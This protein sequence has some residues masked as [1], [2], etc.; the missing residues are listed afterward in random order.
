[1]PRNPTTGVY[2]PVENSFSDPVSGTLIEPVDAKQYNDDVTAALNDV[3]IIVNGMP[4]IGGTSGGI[5]FNNG[6]EVSC[7]DSTS[8][9]ANLVTSGTLSITPPIHDL[10]RALDI[11]QTGTTGGST[12]GPLYFNYIAPFFNSTVTGVRNVSGLQVSLG[13]GASAN[14]V[15]IYGGSF[16]VTQIASGVI[17]EQVGISG[18]VQ[19]KDGLSASNNIYGITGAATVDVGASAPVA[20][21]IESGVAIFTALGVPVRYGVNIDNYGS[22]TATGMDTALSIQGGFPGGSWKNGITFTN[23]GGA[24]APALKTTG[25]MFSA[26]VLMTVDTI[27]DFP[28]VTA[29][30]WILNSPFI[31]MSQDALVL[32]TSAHLGQFSL[33]GPSSTAIQAT[34]KSNGTSVW[35]FGTTTINDFVIN[36]P[37]NSRTPLTIA[38]TNGLTTIANGLTLTGTFTFGG[39]TFALAGNTSLPAI[40]QGDLWYGSAAG[41]ISALAK[42]ASATRYISNTGIS[43]NPAWAQIDL[44]NGVTG[45]LP[46]ANLAQGTARSVLGVTGNSTA[47]VASVQSGA[48]GQILN[49][50]ATTVSWT[51]TPTLGVAGTT[52]GTLG[53][54][55]AT[56]G[57]IS[58]SPQTGALG[59]VTLTLPAATDTL[60]GK[61]TTDELTNK[62]LTTAVGKGTWTASGTWTLPAVTLGGAITY[63]GVTLTNAVTGTGKMVADTTPTLVTPVLGAATAT[64]VAFPGSPA[65]AIAIQNTHAGIPIAN[66]ENAALSSFAAGLY[67]VAEKNGNTSAI[68]NVGGGAATLVTAAGTWVASTTTPAGTKCSLQFNGAAYAIYNNIGS[69]TLFTAI[70][71]QL[72]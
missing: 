24:L 9:A 5:L 48:A 70:P 47:D 29:S 60:V 45:D 40:V 20:V 1:M 31:K 28:L 67:F 69:T 57:T 21:G 55:N 39:F 11:A 63:G 17:G 38:K 59:S 13:T 30:S 56:S 44:S 32:G 4:I 26:E 68:Y 19:I 36:D 46:F 71:I 23:P 42:N 3:P 72:A 12:A 6:G 33:E 50:T 2:T 65:S 7:T 52:V 49:S 16:G 8:G 53:F 61:A 27:F 25:V 54:Q 18:G 14:A 34:L 64:S 37:Q 51:A 62:T 41:T 66:G 43:N 58:L 35:T 15:E 10:R 22:F